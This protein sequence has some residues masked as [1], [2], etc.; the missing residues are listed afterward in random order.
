MDEPHGTDTDRAL[1]VCLELNLDR[2]PIS[3]RVRTEGGEETEFEGWL[4][5]VQA[6][7]RLQ[8]DRKEQR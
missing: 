3:G 8:P 4:G 2:R 5:F 6:L 7:E 1:S